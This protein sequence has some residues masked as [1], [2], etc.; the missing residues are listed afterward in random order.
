MAPLDLSPSPGAKA[1]TL[2]ACEM[3]CFPFELCGTEPPV[4]HPQK[5]DRQAVLHVARGPHTQGASERR[6]LSCLRRLG[7]AYCT[8]STTA[9]RAITYCT[10][11]TTLQ[12]DDYLPY[13]L[14]DKRTITH[15]TSSTTLP[16]GRFPTVPLARRCQAI[17]CLVYLFDE[18]AER[19]IALCTS[20][21]RLPSGRLPTVPL[22]RRCQA[23]DSSLFL[24]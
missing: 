14:H 3:T 21:A 16:S 12:A 10:S 9:N 6:V 20:T 8:S 18:T 4:S 7:I 11:S 19:A 5:Q 2:I 24:W 17:D 23:D 13:P 22:P 1:T 15:C